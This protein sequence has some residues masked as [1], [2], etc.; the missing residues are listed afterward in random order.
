LAHVSVQP[1]KK[2]RLTVDLILQRDRRIS[3]WQIN[4]YVLTVSLI[5]DQEELAIIDEHHLAQNQLYAVPEIETNHQQAT[6]AFQRSDT[7]SCFN[8]KQAGTLMLDTAVALVHATRAR[9]G[10]VVTV[11]DAINGTTIATRD[12]YQLLSCEEEI[13]TAF[14]Q[15]DRDVQNALAFTIGR[16]QV[17]TPDGAE[18]PTGTPPADWA[19]QYRRGGQH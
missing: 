17:L 4:E 3:V 5:C 12:L 18:E 16:E 1:K 9:L 19:N 15:L 6:A 11:A 2:V 7:R 8:G 10:Y 13:I 14:D